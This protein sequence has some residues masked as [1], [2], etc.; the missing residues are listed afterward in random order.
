M[1]EQDVIDALATAVVDEYTEAGLTLATAESCTG[2]WIAKAITDIAGSSACLGY[3]LVTYS[4]AAKSA[5]LGVQPATLESFG[6]VSEPTVREM[7]EGV[8]EV[9]GAN[10][11]VAVSGIA[12]PSGGSAEKPVGTVWFA[13]SCVGENVIQTDA[14]MHQLTGDREAVRARAVV[15]ALQ[16]MRQRVRTCCA[17]ESGSVA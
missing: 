3:G 13:W 7:A 8:L 6:A 15:I 2:G 4:N 1:A 14:E 12:G 5:L 9:S 16:G 11:S 10:C 17:K